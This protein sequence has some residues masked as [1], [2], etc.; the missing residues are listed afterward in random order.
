MGLVDGN[1]TGYTLC[2]CCTLGFDALPDAIVLRNLGK[3]AI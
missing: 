2:F 1:E 3:D